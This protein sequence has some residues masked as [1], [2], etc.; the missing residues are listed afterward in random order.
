MADTKASKVGVHT[1]VQVQVLP[2]VPLTD[3]RKS[4]ILQE[5]EMSTSGG[6]EYALVLET[7]TLVVCGFESLLVYR[8]IRVAQ[9][10]ERPV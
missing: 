4:A 5:V 10:A 1:G 3:S 8:W 9:L 7:S 2:G 6:T